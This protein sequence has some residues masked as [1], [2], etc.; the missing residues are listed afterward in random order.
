MKD[1][2]NSMA[3]VRLTWSLRC[4]RSWQGRAGA[5]AL[6]SALGCTPAPEPASP[7]RGLRVVAAPPPSVSERYCAWYGARGG[8][9]L[10]FGEAPL[11]S[12]LRAAGGDAQAD[13]AEPGPQRVGRFDL[14]REVMLPALE[15]GP[16]GARSGTWDVLVVEDR[17]YYTTFF[18][19][20]GFVDLASGEVTRLPHLGS[21][22]NE[23]APGPG[24]AVTLTR[25]G[26][27]GASS[28][29]GSV[30]WIDRDGALRVEHPLAA[31]DGFTVAPKTPAWDPTRG[32]LWLTTDLLTQAPG[33]P[34]RR[35]A[36]RLDLSGRLLERIASEELHF[37]AVAPD[38]A[39]HMAWVRGRELSLRIGGPEAPGL[40]VDRAF[41]SELDFVQDIQ[42]GS[43]GRALL[44]RWSGVIHVVEPDGAFSTL[45]LPR[46]DPQ[47]L[48]Y[49]GVLQGERL[50]V[51]YCADVSVVCVDAP[52]PHR[53]QR[54]AAG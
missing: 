52:R 44:T 37:A 13:L 48:Y 7:P 49:T 10:Y 4:L 3:S 11:W 54:P 22:L 50:C 27:G 2:M 38:G 47:G 30:L 36:Y 41:P 45:A 12:A 35:D 6:L 31:P 16:P 19:Q 43:D 24:S 17:L 5:L 53:A 42:F 40:V 51:T 25:Y 9:V 46:L 32:H 8:D 18:E 21:A 20:S 14:R 33:G 1:S 29:N 28:E 26:S 34:L 39:L 15:V 23:L